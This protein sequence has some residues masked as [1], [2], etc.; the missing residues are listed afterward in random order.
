MEPERLFELC[1]RL[2]NVALAQENLSKIIVRLGQFRV[3]FSRLFKM[4][5]SF[6]QLSF[7]QK[8]G[9]RSM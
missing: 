2:G 3:Q 6:R 7:A 8:Q 5:S 1:N 4:A 9:T